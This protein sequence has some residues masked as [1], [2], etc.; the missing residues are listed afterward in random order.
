MGYRFSI[1]LFEYPEK[2]SAGDTLFTNIL[3]E[4]NGVAPIYNYLPLSFRLKGEDTEYILKTDIDARNWMPGD[5]VES[6]NLRLPD[7]IKS[8][9]YTIELRLGGDNCPRVKFATDT[10]ISEDGYYYLATITVE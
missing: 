6:P 8:G 1:R 9:E 3:I 7:D 5:T 2:A 4:N 10:S